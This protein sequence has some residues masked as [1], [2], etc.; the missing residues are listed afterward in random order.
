MRDLCL[1]NVI[2]ARDTEEQL[3]SFFD[4]HHVYAVTC[5][6][7]KGTA[8][9]SL[10]SLLGLEKTEKVIMYAMT[11]KTNAKKLMRAMIRELGLEM[12]GRGV[13][14]TIPVGSV[15]GASSFNHLTDGQHI[16]LGEVNEMPQT[17][18]YELIIAISNRGYAATVMDAARSAG[19]MG[20]TIIH[21]RGTN[22]QGQNNFF[23][24][25]IA[26]EKDMLIILTAANQ[27]AA[28]MRAIMEQAGAHSP[29]H[30][31]MFSLPVESVA[32]LQSVIA[33]AAGVEEE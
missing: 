24:L 20:G 15:G 8:S 1:L 16:I 31:V 26:D 19:A 3:L 33:A 4:E 5:I 22:P 13:A 17:F 9:Q 28:L 11:T 25:S 21:A 23:G 30:T 10:L 32:G 2:A 6:P 14:F 29:A 27:K 12:P 18:L 7:C